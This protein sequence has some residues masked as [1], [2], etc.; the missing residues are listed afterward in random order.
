[1][2]EDGEWG[3]E[4][5]IVAL[6]ELYKVNVTVYDELTSSISYL[7]AENENNPH[8]IFINGK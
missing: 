8:C 1:M 3:G 2:L 7:T 5:E 4:P 6:S